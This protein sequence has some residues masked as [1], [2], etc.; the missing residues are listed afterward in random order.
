MPLYVHEHPIEFCLLYRFITQ[1]TP[2]DTMVFGGNFLHSYSVP[3]REDY[4][5]RILGHF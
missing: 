5:F 2:V 4:L 3:M 1:Y